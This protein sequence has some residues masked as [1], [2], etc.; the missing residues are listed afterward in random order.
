MG[1]VRETTNIRMTNYDDTGNRITIGSDVGGVNRFGIEYNSGTE[2][3]ALSQNGA[4]WSNGATTYSTPLNKIGEL[5]TALPAVRLPPNTNTFKLN[6]TLLCDAG[7]TGK[8]TSVNDGS[9][10]VNNNTGGTVTPAIT[11]NQTG[12][13]GGVLVEEIY[14]Q[15]TATTGEFNRMSFYAKSS[16]GAKIEYA[17]IHQNAPSITQGA[18]RGRLDFDV[19]VSGTSTNLLSLNGSS[20]QVDINNAN[21]HLNSNSIV[22]CSNISTPPGNFY[23]KG[24]NEYYSL[25][26]NSSPTILEDKLRWA[27]VSLG[28]QPNWTQDINVN[29]F[30]SGIENI[31]AS[32]YGFGGYWWVGTDLGNIYY[33]FDSGASWISFGGYGGR[34]NCFQVYQG[35]Y[36]AVGGAF[37][38]SY[39]YLFGIDSG[40]STFD[41]TLGSNGLNGEV[42]CMYDNATNSC[43]Y[44]G[45]LFDAFNGGS[46]YSNKFITWAYGVFSWYPFSNSVGSGFNGGDVLGITQDPGSNFVVVGGT[47]TDVVVSGFSSGLSYCFTFQTGMGYDVSSYFGIGASLN[48]PV[49]SVLA[50]SS[51]VL[52]GG[53]FTNPLVYPSWSD[54]YGIYITWNGT[55]WD[56]NNIPFYS[57]YGPVR[58]FVFI[59]TTGDYFTIVDNGSFDTLI[60]NSIQTPNIPVGSRWNCIVYNGSNTCYATDN[61]NSVG[62][63]FYNLNQSTA[64]TISASGGQTF[65]TYGNLGLTTITML[66]AGSSFEFIYSISSNNWWAIALNGCSLS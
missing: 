17:R 15:R 10:I 22:G 6:N 20:V 14:N 49:Y 25:P 41:I 54:S 35:M 56:L 59:P 16:T 8:T 4:T 63:L 57:P 64:L 51:G 11:L 60:K 53:S 24:V 62:F 43:L 46:S 52:V 50:Y 39:Q 44:I 7:T 45:G 42:K 19:N 40:L 38:S 1:T 23:V 5:N 66:G 34:I 37:T 58:Q 13:A 12:T 18:T 36:M 30:P 21:L 29:S 9:I 61:Q 55:N 32:Q 28:K 33:S 26:S 47:F 3:F 31:T 65:N 27:G 2:T 48:N